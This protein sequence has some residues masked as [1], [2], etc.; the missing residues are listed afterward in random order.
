M[1]FRVKGEYVAVGTARIDCPGD[2]PDGDMSWS[3]GVNAE[4]RSEGSLGRAGVKD[5]SGIAMRD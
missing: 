2:S 3:E 1:F 5:A 4:H